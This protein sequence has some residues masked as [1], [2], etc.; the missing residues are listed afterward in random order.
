[1][2]TAARASVNY[3]C[4]KCADFKRV[5]QDRQTANRY[6]ILCFDVNVFDVTSGMLA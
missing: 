5:P 1:M 3:E 2:S 4:C 6:E